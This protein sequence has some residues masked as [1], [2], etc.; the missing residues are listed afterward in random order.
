MASWLQSAYN[1]NA[2]QMSVQL[3]NSD[4]TDS[5]PFV[6]FGPNP[7]LTFTYSQPAPSVPVGTG[8]VPS[9]TFLSFPV[10]DRV[11]LQVNVG[12][13]NALLTTSDLTLPEIEARASPSA[14]TTTA[15]WSARS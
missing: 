10:S 11:S 1:S 9:A 5:G 2:F 14:T 13:G 8:P 6:E 4:E 15:C 7:T 12:S 3:Q